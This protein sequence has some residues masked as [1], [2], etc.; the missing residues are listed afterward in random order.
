ML[1]NGTEIKAKVLEVSPTDIKYRRQDNPDGPLYSTG[2]ADVFLIQYANGTKDVLNPAPAAPPA[3]TNRGRFNA[4]RPADIAP[5]D[6]QPDALQRLRY[7]GGLLNRHFQA[8][9]GNRLNRQ[10]MP[11]LMRNEAGAMH[12]FEQ[13]RS[14]RRWAYITG[15][16]A[17]A[18]V[19]TGA[20]LA[21][22]DGRGHNDR[23]GLGRGNTSQSTTHI[24][25]E[26]DGNGR[27]TVGVAIAG[28]GLLLGVAALVLDR[29]ATIQFRR[30]ANRYNGRSST[31]LNLTPAFGATT[32]GLTLNF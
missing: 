28:G 31:G 5:A 19:G 21:L 20:A 18:L 29:K 26:H 11:G 17:I 1:K 30:A 6:R 3:P 9:P 15:G 25:S 10:D 32:A 27:A 13:G 22:I 24:N 2:T 4:D 7:R 8:D 23:D 16:T 14:L 12:A